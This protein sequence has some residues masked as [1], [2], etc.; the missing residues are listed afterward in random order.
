MRKPSTS[1][2]ELETL[3]RIY[4]HS[5]GYVVP[6]PIG[7]HPISTESIIRKTHRFK[8]SYKA[9]FRKRLRRNRKR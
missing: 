5:H 7:Q 9:L 3:C 2:E 8:K 4:N 6:G 1:V